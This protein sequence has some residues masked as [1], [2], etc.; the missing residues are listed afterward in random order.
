MQIWAQLAQ[1]LIE[2]QTPSQ[3]SVMLMMLLGSCPF[4]VE[5]ATIPNRPYQ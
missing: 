5:E 3:E 4:N 1:E 2:R